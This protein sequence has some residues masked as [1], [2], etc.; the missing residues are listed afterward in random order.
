L[1]VSGGFSAI[2][3]T[4]G[5]G[6][7]EFL[8]ADSLRFEG[9][10]DSSIVRFRA[11]ADLFRAAGEERRYIQSL[12]GVADNLVRKSRYVEAEALLDSITGQSYELSKQD[13]S[14]FQETYFLRG[15]IASYNNRFDEAL[16]CVERSLA[17]GDPS[18]PFA[19]NVYHLRGVIFWRKGQ[20]D[21]AQRS[22]QRAREIQASSDRIPGVDR[23][24]TLT[25]TGALDDAL[26]KYMSAMRW[27]EEALSQLA[28]DHQG[29]SEFAANCY[30]YMA[31]TSRSLGEFEAALEYEKHALAIFERLYG[32][33]HL[34][35]AAALAQLGDVYTWM[36]D[37]IPAREHY[38]EALSIMSRLLEPGHA[39]IAEME[40][41]LAH[42]ALERNE[43]DT[44]SALIARAA[45]SKS[46]SLPDHPWMGDIYE[47]MGDISYA[48]KEFAQSLAH[49]R[50]AIAIRQKFSPAGLDLATL[51]QKLGEASFEAGNIG[52]ATDALR[53]A[54]AQQDSSGSRNPYLVSAILRTLGDVERKQGM[55]D[56]ALRSY[57]RSLEELSADSQNLTASKH[58]IRLLAR[59]GSVLKERSTRLHGGT[60]D[61]KSA[62][63]CYDSAADLL[64]RLRRE[65]QASE[66]K[67]ALQ[68]EV[69]PV[70]SAGLSLS[71]EIYRR[72]GE[73]EYADAAFRFSELSKASVLRETMQEARAKASGGVPDSLLERER[74][75]SALVAVAETRLLAHPEDSS[76]V[77]AYRH[78]LFAARRERNRLHETMVADFP[79]YR[80]LR[81]E[82]G[83]ASVRDV[84]QALPSGTVL[85]SYTLVDDSLMLF[86]VS[87]KGLRVHHLGAYGPIEQ[88]ARRLLAAI[89]TSERSLYPREARRLYR[90]V[91]A[92]AKKDF[93]GSSRLV[94]VPDGI[95]HNVP[96]V[97]LLT[98]DRAVGSRVDLTRLPYLIASYEVT[99]AL[100]GTLFRESVSQKPRPPVSEPAFA[101]YAPVFPD[102]ADS[103]TPSPGLAGAERSVALDGKKYNALRFSEEE[104]QAIAAAFDGAGAPVAGFFRGDATKARFLATAGDYSIVHIATHA[105]IDERSPG[106]SGILFSPSAGTVATDDDVLY[107]GETS[108][109]QLNASLVVLGACKSGTG[110]YVRGEGVMALTRGFTSAG[111]RNVAYSL[112]KVSDRYT[113]L[114]MRKFYSR[115]LKGERY[116][117]ALRH[118]ELEMIADRG[119]AFPLA[120]AGFVIAGE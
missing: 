119:T 55:I 86:V 117:A 109:L 113:S 28:S 65:Y 40:R 59:Q 64:L 107:V 82:E 5:P 79:A 101:G 87:T 75:L 104:V 106:L 111:A 58:A 42:L 97:A 96:F 54:A 51:Y 99:Y 102:S 72:T 85:L 73:A 43:L 1:L 114:L 20:Y 95:L 78:R 47:D 11:A 16:A 92:P 45:L 67:I 56:E 110:K 112:W 90:K 108:A 93:A 3:A 9:L 17:L 33:Q 32:H 36:G 13:S 91:L 27:Y 48:R 61:L 103:M 89:T 105:V 52:E 7:K 12:N 53:R 116:S 74:R 115:V 44:A 69:L 60:R 66:S 94:V 23:A 8:A 18:D 120:W 81:A 46:K 57:R 39:S 29:E 41:K 63:A 34:A 24:L 30:H 38:Q 26:G 14:A 37:Y 2:P 4:R 84:C 10:F 71:A 80:R 6:E 62:V 49:Y 88:N 15:T 19:A 31:V 100:S 25:I 35:V 118:A 68:E 98:G 50:R 76:V 77:G 83:T 22:L 70:F 21:S